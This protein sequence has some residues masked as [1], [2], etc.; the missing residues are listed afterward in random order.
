[1][2]WDRAVM[3]A[4]LSQRYFM[5][6]FSFLPPPG[7]LW[8][9][10]TASLA[11]LIQLGKHDCGRRC[12][13]P[14]LEQILG[15]AT[16]GSPELR[17]SPCLGRDCLVCH[18][19]MP[20]PPGERVDGFPPVPWDLPPLQEGKPTSTSL[21]SQVGAGSDFEGVNKWFRVRGVC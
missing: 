5:S 6:R 14:E 7:A 17:A 13:R 20:A 19:L 18:Y 10:H 15:N 8:S 2:G 11:C 21:P 3:P 1:M 16:L 9:G 4:G 12:W